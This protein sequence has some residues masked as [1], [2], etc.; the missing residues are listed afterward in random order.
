VGPVTTYVIEIVVTVV[1]VAALAT[2]MLYGAR[3]VGVGRSAGPLEQIGRLHLEG[4]RTVYLVR[5]GSEVYVLAASEAGMALL[6]VVG[7][8]TLPEAPQVEESFGEVLARVM[9]RSR[10]ASGEGEDR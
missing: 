8:D 6:G 2:V 7:R 4:R 9:G 3:R 5:V 1:G 10:P